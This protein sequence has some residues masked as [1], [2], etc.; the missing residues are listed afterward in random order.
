MPRITFVNEHMT[1]ETEPG[2]LL[3]EIAAELGIAVCRETF[4]GTGIGDYTCWVKGEPGATS[5]PTFLERLLGAKGQ[6]RMANRTRVLGDVQV[7]T[8]AGPGNRLRAPRPIAPPPS[9]ATDPEAPR[10][11]I[12]ASGSA[13]FPYGDPRAVGHGKREPIAAGALEAK[14]AKEKKAKA[15]GAPAKAAEA[16]AKVAEAPAKVAEAPAGGEAAAAA[17]EPART[18]KAAAKAPRTAA[19]TATTVEGAATAAET[20]PAAQGVAVA[21]KAA[22][23]ATEATPAAA[24]SPTPATETASTA[25][26]TA[27][28]APKTASTSPGTASTPPGT[29]STP[30]GTT[31]AVTE[32]AAMPPEAEASAPGSAA[33]AKEREGGASE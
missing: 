33:T 2:R 11:P 3:S 27:A 30:P 29:A 23:P 5:P 9:P 15:A 32:I 4:R 12:D 25:P 16:P 24:A 20:A 10:K 1:V 7:W 6:R 14:A 21:P 22:T 17:P 31:S 28:A 26:E 19:G 13:A 18:P 8:Q